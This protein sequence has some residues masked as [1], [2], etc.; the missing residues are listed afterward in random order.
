MA[1][2][3]KAVILSVVGVA[4][5]LGIT[6]WL[7]SRKSKKI[8]Q[9]SGA[10]GIVGG[11]AGTVVPGGVVADGTYVPPYTPPYMGGTLGGGLGD[12]NSQLGIG[13]SSGIS[14]G[15]SGNTENNGMEE[16]SHGGRV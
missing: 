1:N 12:I 3:N 13:I 10:T 6:I 9:L 11:A 15:S 4:A 16:M 5:A 7:L 2:G 14:A 8:D